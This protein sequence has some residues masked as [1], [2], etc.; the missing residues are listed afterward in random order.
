M[1]QAPSPANMAYHPNARMLEASLPDAQQGNSVVRAQIAG[2]RVDAAVE[3][4][5]ARSFASLSTEL[6]AMH[7]FLTQSGVSVNHL[8]LSSQGEHPGRDAPPRQQA[9]ENGQGLKAPAAQASRD[10]SFSEGPVDAS[11]HGRISVRA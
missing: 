10:R 4:D 5:S 11:G 6:P 7:Q 1:D 2:G 3:V 9:S 8:S